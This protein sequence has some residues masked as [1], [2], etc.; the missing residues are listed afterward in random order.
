MDVTGALPDSQAL[1]NEYGDLNSELV[2]PLR[3]AVVMGLACLGAAFAGGH[4]IALRGWH[5]LPEAGFALLLG[6]VT[7]GVSTTYL[8]ESVLSHF[9]F[10]PEFFMI[11]LLPPII[12][13]AGFNM[14][15]QTFFANIIPM[16]GYAFVGTFISTMVVG[17]VC[18]YAGQY[19]LCLPLGP[20][21][22]LTFGALISAT[23]PVT[24]LSVFQAIGVQPELFALVF[25]ESVLNDAIALV[26]ANTIIAFRGEEVTSAHVTEAFASFVTVFACSMAV[27]S[28]IGALSAWVYKKLNL[29]LHPETLFVE[30]ALSVVWPYSAYYL[31]E[32]LGLSGIVAILFCGI[33][34]ARYTR[35]NLSR[36]AR[37]LTARSYKVVALIAETYI[38][39]YLGLSFFALPI[40]SSTPWDLVIIGLGACF[41][42]RAVNILIVSLLLFCI[43]FS[44][45]FRYQVALW[46]SGLRGGVAFAIASLLYAHHEFEDA[47]HDLAI[48]QVTLMIATFTIFFFGG[49]IVPISEWLDVMHVDGKSDLHSRDFSVTPRI[50]QRAKSFAQRLERNYLS[51][52][53]SIHGAGDSF[54]YEQMVEGAFAREN[55]P[56]IG[57]KSERSTPVPEGEG[58]LS[59]L[60]EGGEEDDAE[61]KGD[62]EASLS[63]NPAPEARTEPVTVAR[64]RPRV[65]PAAGRPGENPLVAPENALGESGLVTRSL[66]GRQASLALAQRAPEL[67]ISPL[68]LE[69]ARLSQSGPRE[70]HGPRGS[71][72]A[73]FDFDM[74]GNRAR[75]RA[76]ELEDQVVE[77]QGAL[78]KAQ[79]E[80]QLRATKL[81]ELRDEQRQLKATVDSYKAASE[82]QQATL[83]RTGSH[84]STLTKIVE[85]FSITR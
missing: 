62:E 66:R 58:G 32:A 85:R 45:P 9:V 79:A 57:P 48:L 75:E 61:G 55:G 60:E 81:S 44:V 69:I 46:C 51:P 22:S 65:A 67:M 10:N 82:A 29:R 17:A 36:P 40:L 78:K 74:L 38:F 3:I 80:L 31:S 50:T 39:V 2:W 18:Y 12:F 11:W 1:G 35:F 24:V 15:Q 30:T 23:D 4:I 64:P 8:D 27:G 68:E 26:L 13:E 5:W 53:L 54:G 73:L 56:G 47:E 41:A 71:R 42:G 19:G 77:L 43:G 59:A 33:L 84:K 76:K 14:N 25:G 20:I 34:M 52:F 72:N 16:C 28:F 70:Y 7:S 6:A 37:V 21:A 63:G 83:R 49:A